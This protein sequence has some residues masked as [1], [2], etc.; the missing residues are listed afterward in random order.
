MFAAIKYAVKCI[1]NC[2]RAA[3][4]TPGGR[5]KKMMTAITAFSLGLMAL[6]ASA[7]DAQL[8]RFEFSQIEMGVPFKILLYAP[9]STS[10]NRAAKA[11]F[12]RIHELN[13]MLS[14]YDP[15][16]ELS[17]LS[18]RSP[19]SEPVHVSD[20]LWLVLNRSQQLAEQSEGAFDITVDHT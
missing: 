17:R 5:A 13:G 18:A 20:P 8:T 11:A 3:V 10:A 1:V 16:S 19:T 14:D 9:D 12:A 6:A 15:E 2:T 7:D 4:Q